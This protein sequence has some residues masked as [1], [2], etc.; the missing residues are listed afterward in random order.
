MA[1][2]IVVAAMV[3]A[4]AVVVALACWIA[5]RLGEP[6]LREGS[7]PTAMRTLAVWAFKILGIVGAVPL[8][9]AGVL[10][11]GGW[12]NGTGSEFNW[13][14][15]G[16]V[17]SFAGFFVSV[18]T[19][20]GIVFAVRDFERRARDQEE[21]RR[22]T[23]IEHAPYVRVDLGSL[24]SYNEPGFIPP[25]TRHTYPLASLQT[26]DV[27][28]AEQQEDQ[29]FVR[30]NVAAAWRETFLAELWRVAGPR[31]TPPVNLW[32]RNLQ[33]QQLGFAY[34]IEIYLAIEWSSRDKPDG[35]GLPF[36]SI[37]LT[38]LAPEQTTAVALLP[39]VPMGLKSLRVRVLQVDYLDRWG[40][41]LRDYHGAVEYCYDRGTERR[42]R[43]VRKFQVFKE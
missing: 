37:R 40:S 23:L 36:F 33:R 18:I 12:A 11:G 42:F 20:A 5:F 31:G 3:V 34:N 22:R 10:V 38:Y 8:L 15:L 21:S 4:A 14:A 13:S 17:V 39:H 28:Q 29:R 26:D 30:R 24:P 6:P 1:Q 16:T 2:A 19:A 35:D 9:V 27:V 7:E 41:S 25:S 43:N 32:V